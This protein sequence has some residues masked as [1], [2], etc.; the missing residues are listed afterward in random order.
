MMDTNVWKT[1]I[2]KHIVVLE[3]FLKNVLLRKHKVSATES[4]REKKEK[5]VSKLEHFPILVK[6][7]EKLSGSEIVFGFS[8]DWIGLLSDII[9]DVHEPEQ[10]EI[11]KDL[12]REFMLHFLGVV[13]KSFEEIGIEIDF[14]ECISMKV[15]ELKRSIKDQD[16]LTAKLIAEQKF[17]VEEGEQLNLEIIVGLSDPKDEVLKTLGTQL[18]DEN[19]FINGTYEKVSSRIAGLV[20]LDR[21]TK[22]PSHRT[23]D[24]RKSAV[25][26]QGKEVEFEA[27]DKASEVKNDREVSTIG[28]LKDVKMNVSVELGH[29]EMSLGNVL[30]LVRGSVIELEKLAGE[31]VDI[32]V[33]GHTIAEGDVV[34]IDEHFGVR[35]SKLLAGK[36]NIQELR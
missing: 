1:G 7:N 2:E 23:N 16:F 31:P 26:V 14:T 18:E 4:S 29:R 24:E 3:A 33:N 5:F 20:K 21:V 11:T 34:V 12:F 9:L 15:G 22:T 25:K 19:P 10:N 30:K 35:I 32:L 36:Q 6:A 17:D 27:F 28:F 8:S 13:K